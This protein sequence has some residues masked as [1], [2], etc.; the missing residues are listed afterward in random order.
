M[1][2][3]CV[4][5][6]IIL[7][8]LSADGLWG[9]LLDTSGKTWTISVDHRV[10]TEPCSGKFSKSFDVVSLFPDLLLWFVINHFHFDSVS[11]LEAKYPRLR[12]SCFSLKIAFLC[13]SLTDFFHIIIAPGGGPRSR[14]C[15]N[16]IG[17][18][19]FLHLSGVAINISVSIGGCPRLIRIIDRIWQIFFFSALPRNP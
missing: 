13:C 17:P 8:E 10:H 9:L 14:L 18:P 1:D 15:V 11:G 6:I 4:Y 12:L 5:R 19:H 16:F 7:F 2:W 3:L